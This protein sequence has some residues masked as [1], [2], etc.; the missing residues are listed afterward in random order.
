[1][2]SALALVLVVVVAIVGGA[3]CPQLA[4]PLGL[5]SAIGSGVL[6]YAGGVLVLPR[7]ACA[8]SRVV[9]GGLVLSDPD[10]G[11]RGRRLLLGERLEPR[12]W[13]GAI[14][15][16]A[17]VLGVWLDSR[18]VESGSTERRT[19]PNDP[20]PGGRLRRRIGTGR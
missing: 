13:V 15:V 4:T 9:G 12:Q 18:T 7:G 16:L 2:P 1:M 5:A 19:S 8:T 3:G 6:Y 20:G 11:G 14:I 17:A 10:R